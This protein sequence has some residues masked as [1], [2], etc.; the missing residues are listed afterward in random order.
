MSYWDTILADSSVMGDESPSSSS[1][2]T[3]PASSRP[4]QNNLPVLA[5]NIS[6]ISAA[7]PPIA[8]VYKKGGYKKLEEIREALGIPAEGLSGA[9]IM[10]NYPDWQIDS[11]TPSPDE[12]WEAILEAV[13]E[14]FEE[15]TA[16]VWKNGMFLK[17]KFNRRQDRLRFQCV[18]L[19]DGICATI[20]SKLV[21]QG[22]NESA[23]R[24]RRCE[25]NW[26]IRD[27][28]ERCVLNARRAFRQRQESSS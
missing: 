3:G 22:Y 7:Q 17:W 12:V 20:I 9:E 27:L 21:S 2:P 10:Q 13:R 23:S 11:Q 24:L 18:A 14:S 19:Q 26:A 15:Y 8:G 6:S 25:R 4:V 1:K 28:V 16:G 5:P